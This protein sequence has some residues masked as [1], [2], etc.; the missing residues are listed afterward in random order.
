MVQYVPQLS[1]LISVHFWLLKLKKTFIKTGVFHH[2]SCVC[3]G[4][5]GPEL[6]FQAGFCEDVAVA[7]VINI[8][9]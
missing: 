2:A 6:S 7:N 3:I 5:H 1:A 9:K 4:Q 8:S